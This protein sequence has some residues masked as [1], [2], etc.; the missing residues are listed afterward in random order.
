MENAHVFRLERPCRMEIHGVQ[1]VFSRRS[2]VEVGVRVLEFLEQA[3]SSQPVETLDLSPLCALNV[4][5]YPKK[6]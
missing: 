4:L 5:S 3:R 2:P 6:V 1:V